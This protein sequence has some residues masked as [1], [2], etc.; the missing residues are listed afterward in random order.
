MVMAAQQ[1]CCPVVLCIANRQ[2]DAGIA[3]QK[4]VI[5]SVNSALLLPQVI[6]SRFRV[7][8]VSVRCRAFWGGDLDHSREAP[9]SKRSD[10]KIPKSPAEHECIAQLYEAKAQD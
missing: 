7:S 3:V 4:T 1:E 6:V 8:T 2:A 10:L 5:A 9:K